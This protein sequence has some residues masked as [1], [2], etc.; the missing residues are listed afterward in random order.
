MPPGSDF[1]QLKPPSEAYMMGQVGAQ[2][3]IVQ[4]LSGLI[5]SQLSVLQ[6]MMRYSDKKSQ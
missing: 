2:M 6:G 1:Q 4:R 5:K 3:N